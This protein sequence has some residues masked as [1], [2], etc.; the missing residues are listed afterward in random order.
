MKKFITIA[1]LTISMAMSAQTQD[2]VRNG[3]TFSAA[4]SEHVR[5]TLVTKYSWEDASGKK[6]PIVVN[7]KTGACYICK[8]SKN[9]KW[10]RQ[11]MAKMISEDICKMLGIERKERRNG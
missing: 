11:Y 4:K 3:D 7:K 2:I 9:G 8:V 10:Y 1:L 5:D 6:Y